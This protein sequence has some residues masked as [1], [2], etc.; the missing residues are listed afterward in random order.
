[1]VH[2]SNT[3]RAGPLI[4]RVTT[5]SRSDVRSTVVGFF[6][7][8]SSLSLVASIDLLLPFQVLDDPV[9]RVEARVPELAMQ[10]DPGRLFF[11]S[12]RAK[13]GTSEGMNL[14]AGRSTAGNATC[15]G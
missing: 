6:M 8:A 9:Q 2:A 11:E 10:L 3:R 13:A 5:S 15:A 1:V 4:V 7:G 12:A 14:R